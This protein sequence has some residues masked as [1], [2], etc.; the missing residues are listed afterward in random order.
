M[1]SG[2]E[3]SDEESDEA[4]VGD[5][6]RTIKNGGGGMHSSPRN[7]YSY[8][9]AEYDAEDVGDGR[10]GLEERRDD[11]LHAGVARDEAQRA[12]D[13][14]HTKDAEGAQLWDG[15]REEDGKGDHHNRKV[16]LV[17]SVAA[18]TCA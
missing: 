2:G 3:E 1:E 8:L 6:K 4:R 13:A 16:D 18:H 17:P 11:Q 7:E 9:E 12:E 10:H 15:V 14:H 5:V